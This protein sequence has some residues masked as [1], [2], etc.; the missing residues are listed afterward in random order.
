MV[1]I[2]VLVSESDVAVRAFQ[3]HDD[4]L[5]GR[6]S[7]AHPVLERLPVEHRSPTLVERLDAGLAHAR[8]PQTIMA[9]HTT[10]KNTTNASFTLSPPVKPT[11]H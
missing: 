10:T 3:R 11:H 5:L 7:S 9:T 8:E 4:Q 2:A 6:H 1:E